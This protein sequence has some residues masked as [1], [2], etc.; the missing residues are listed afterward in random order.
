MNEVC[1]KRFEFSPVEMNHMPF[2]TITFSNNQPKVLQNEKKTNNEFS[3][4]T[5]FQHIFIVYKN[6]FVR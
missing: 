2:L 6:I 1:D 4:N 3:R 5:T